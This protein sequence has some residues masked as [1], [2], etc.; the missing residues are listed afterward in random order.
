MLRGL[1]HEHV[2]TL[3]NPGELLSAVNQSFCSILEEGRIGSFASAFALT[4]DLGAGVFRFSSAGHPSPFLLRQGKTAPIT[5]CGGPEGED[6]GV[7]GLLRGVRYPTL[8]MD[9][10]SG[11][12][13]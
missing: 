5:P 13:M 2:E 3:K 4:V 12:T 1:V 8:E 10:Q 9:I 11:K 6:G 7:L